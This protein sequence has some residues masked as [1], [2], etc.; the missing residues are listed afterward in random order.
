MCTGLQWGVMG[1]GLA[2][3]ISNWI[4]TVVMVGLLLRKGLL[5][6]KELMVPPALADVLPLLRSGVVLSARVVITFGEIQS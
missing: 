4:T 5:R 3:S 1:S 2:S 6:P